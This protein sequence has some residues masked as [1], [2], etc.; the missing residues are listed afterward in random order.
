MRAFQSKK[1]IWWGVGM[2]ALVFGVFMAA[3]FLPA[4]SA[5]YGSDAPNIDLP[6]MSNVPPDHAPQAVD[7]DLDE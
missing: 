3:V 6:S 5:P 2:L 1:A 4:A 7:V